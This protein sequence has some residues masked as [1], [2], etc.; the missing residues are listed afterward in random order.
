MDLANTYEIHVTVKTDDLMHFRRQCERLQV[1]PIILDLQDHQGLGVMQDVMTS[2][3]YKGKE[4][5]DHANNLKSR[6]EYRGFE[7]LRVK[8][9]TTP[10]HSCVPT[11]A[12]GLQVNTPNYFESHI[13]VYTLPKRLPALRTYAASKGVHV[14]QNILKKDTR[15]G[16]W[17]LA[18]LRAYTGVLE[19][20]QATVVNFTAGVPVSGYDVDKVEVEYVIY[21]T[22]TNHD[23]LWISSLI[24]KT[25]S[26]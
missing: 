25:N 12:N 15:G 2:S 9:E 23:H 17:I 5:L 19:E 24:A 22:N 16:V 7:V 20:F 14:S 6:L 3:K 1:K 10:F 4:P 8:I 21:D 11:V 13:R 26:K 18:T